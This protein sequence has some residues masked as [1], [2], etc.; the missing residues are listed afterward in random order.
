MITE[1]IRTWKSAKDQILTAEVPQETR[2]YKPVS[3]QELIDLTLESI[4]QS[5]FEI[6]SQSYISGRE[7]QV[8]TGKYGISSVQD[9]EMR[10]QIAWQNSY[11][12][13]TTLKFAIG[14]QVIVCENGM[15]SGD[16]GHFKTKHVGDVQTFAPAAITEYIKQSGDSFKTMQNDREGLKAHEV[17]KERRAEI[18]GRMF[19]NDNLIQSSQMN[20][21]RKELIDPTHDYG[22][23]DSL[24]ELYNHS[25]FAMKEIHPRI[26]MKDHIALHE[27][28]MS[29]ASSQHN[30][31]VAKVQ[32]DMM[33][34]LEMF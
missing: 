30:K 8:A 1:T 14:A 23:P 16:N 20:V 2:T 3:H 29:E 18:L 27:F 12:K 7:G 6:A 15:V 13:T 31:D 19:F 33:N 25:T 21:I 11:D 17:S 26:W 5:G 4:H 28:F 22:C 10:L 24:W 34:Q 32:Q 9:S